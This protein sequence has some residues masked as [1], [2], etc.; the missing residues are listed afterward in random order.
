MNQVTNKAIEY[1]E[2]PVGH[3]ATIPKGTRV[4]P[5]TNLPGNKFWAEPWDGM[6][7]NAEAWQR[8]YGFL[9]EADDVEVE[10]WA[11]VEA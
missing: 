10:G 2:A 9:I 11:E 7:H 5:A 3:I 1:S 4:I 6:D 8:V